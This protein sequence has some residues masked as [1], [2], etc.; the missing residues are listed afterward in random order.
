M[1]V[2]MVPSSDAP[3]NDMKPTCSSLRSSHAGYADRS[4]AYMRT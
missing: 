4:A 1:T 3:N 2:V